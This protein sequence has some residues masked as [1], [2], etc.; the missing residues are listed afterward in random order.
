MLTA[1]LRRSQLE[2]AREA[3]RARRAADRRRDEVVEVTVRRRRE[4]ERAEAMS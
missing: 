3:E 4:L 2:L 1:S